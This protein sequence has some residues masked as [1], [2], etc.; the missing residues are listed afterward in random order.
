MVPRAPLSAIVALVLALSATPAIDATPQDS[1]TAL[2]IRAESLAYDL[3]HREALALMRRSVELAPDDPQT[4]RALANVLW[5]NLL[6]QRGAVTV[7]HYLGSFSSATVD[8]SKP[9]ADI[10]AEFRREV[11]K[12]IQLSE[13][14]VAARPDDAQAH[15]D[16]GTAVGLQASYVATVEGRMLAGFSAARRAYDEHERVLALDPVPQGR[17]T[18]CRHLSLRRLDVVAADADDG[19]RGRIRRRAR[20]RDPDDRAGRR[21]PVRQPHR[22]AV[23]A[24]SDVQPGAALRRGARGAAGTA[25]VASP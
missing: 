17:R 3:D 19:L 22:R 10:D 5:L 4:H 7:D 15:Y 9:P 14:R 20:R 11:G 6:F 12:A 18:G 2:R 21:P 23:R 25:P 8:L 13:Q 24:G 16:L 1:A